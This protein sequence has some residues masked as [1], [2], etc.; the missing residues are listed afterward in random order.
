MKEFRNFVLD[1]CILVFDTEH[2]CLKLQATNFKNKE[3]TVYPK[4]RPHAGFLQ[5]P[6]V[7]KVWS[8]PVRLCST[9][10]ACTV[11]YGVLRAGGS[12]LLP[13]GL[14]QARLVRLFGHAHS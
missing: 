4:P 8:W 2:V 12:Q 5:G 6:Q 13:S 3:V 11:W 1:N 10:S 7:V 9:W 14:Q